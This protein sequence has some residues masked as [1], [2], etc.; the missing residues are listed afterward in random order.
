[1]EYFILN[2]GNKMP[3]IGFGTYEL[4]GREGVFAIQEAI[5]N[6]YRA[7][8]TAVNYE[9]EGAVGRAVKN[10]DIPRDQL[11]ITSKLPGRSQEYDKAVKQIQES[12]YRSD[13]D[14]FDLY[15][16]H[17]PNPKEGK[18][19]EAWQ[20]LID[21]QKWGL[22]RSIGVSNF[23]PEHIKKLYQETHVLPAV[24][25]VEMHPYWSAPEVR[26]FD[27]ENEIITQA[28]SPLQ[29]GGEAFQNPAVLK[30]A[31]KYGKTPAQI[32]LRWQTELNVMPIPKSSKSEHQ[33]SNLS[34]FDFKL[35]DREIES[36]VK[37]D[38]SKAK[39]YDSDEHEEF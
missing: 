24:N 35:T 12:L 27:D 38:T 11:F 28:W 31:R 18:Y 29:R 2:D 10:S 37:M 15:L 14:Y 30:L 32:I 21:A 6:G 39:K 34:I 5:K 3:M 33:I 22:V 25:Q 23:K 7:I 19:V 1:M 13:L 20:A 26:A 8:D 36:I 4:Q 17:W 9:N 16:I